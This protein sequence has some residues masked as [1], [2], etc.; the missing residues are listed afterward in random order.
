VLEEVIKAAV[1]VPLPIRGVT[2]GQSAVSL[3]EM[4]RT[5]PRSTRRI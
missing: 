4:W 3:D 5:A 2:V 1:V